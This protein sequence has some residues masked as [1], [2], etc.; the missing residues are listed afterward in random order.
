MKNITKQRTTEIKKLLKMPDRAIN[1]RDIPEIKDF[2]RAVVGRFYRPIK[3]VI[4]IRVDADVLDWFKTHYS[5]YQPLV[6]QAL[7]EYMETHR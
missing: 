7:R 1:T 5:K 6:N 2:K 3:Q 4:T